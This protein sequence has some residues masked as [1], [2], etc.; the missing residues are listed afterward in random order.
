MFNPVTLKRFYSCGMRSV[1]AR[2]PL[3]MLL[4]LLSSCRCLL[5]SRVRAAPVCT[6][7]VTCG[8]SFRPAG[9]YLTSTFPGS[10]RSIVCFSTSGFPFW[11]FAVP[12]SSLT[13]LKQ[14]RLDSSR[15]RSIRPRIPN[16]PFPSQTHL[17]FQFPCPSLKIPDSDSHSRSTHHLHFLV[18]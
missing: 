15:F 1:E 3:G 14:L 6:L 17:L 4:D 10:L 12:N 8:Q 7:L 18:P 11:V 13:T 5:R 9:D 16:P 2:T